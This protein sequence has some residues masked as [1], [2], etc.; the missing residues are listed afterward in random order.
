[1]THAQ[2]S[3]RVQEVFATIK[4]KSSADD[5]QAYLKS[6]GYEEA[7]AA[8]FKKYPPLNFQI[9]A[10]EIQALRNGRCINDS[11]EIITNS[12]NDKDP[13]TKLLYALIWKNGDVAKLKHI[14]NGVC[15]SGDLQSEDALVFQQFGKSLQNQSEPI[16]DQHVLRAFAVYKIKNGDEQ[17]VIKVRKK[18]ILKRADEGLLAAYKKWVK[19]LLTQVPAEEQPRFKAIL[20]N[21]LFILGKELKIKK[22]KHSNPDIL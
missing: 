14:I 2:A 19:E 18:G 11:N 20:D 7:Q 5:L 13:L 8:Y 15:S 21:I 16:I 9:T 12:I 6:L 4:Q 17:Q 3:Q 1:M 22:D 10:T